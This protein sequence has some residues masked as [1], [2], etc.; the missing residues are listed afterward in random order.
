[1]IHAEWN[2]KQ[3]ASDTIRN[4][5]DGSRNQTIPP[6]AYINGN[7]LASACT[8]NYTLVT[9]HRLQQLFSSP[10]EQQKSLRDVCNVTVQ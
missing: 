4:S 3:T 9:F 1:M 7:T 6:K 2:I 5:I 8:K 10:P